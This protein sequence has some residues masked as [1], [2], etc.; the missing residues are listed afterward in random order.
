MSEMELRRSLL[1]LSFELATR[2]VLEDKWGVLGV[3]R[4][5]DREWDT[6]REALFNPT[7][8]DVEGILPESSSSEIRVLNLCDNPG[9]GR[10]GRCGVTGRS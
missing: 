1:A 4:D 8:L 6:E 3:T 2:R 9:W 7:C 5:L 10:S